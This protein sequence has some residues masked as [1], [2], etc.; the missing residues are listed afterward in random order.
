[1][2]GMGGGGPIRTVARLVWDLDQR[3][4]FYL[5]DNRIR[6]PPKAGLRQVASRKR[7]AALGR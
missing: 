3:F 4:D 5:P 1:M 6:S 7:L 2:D